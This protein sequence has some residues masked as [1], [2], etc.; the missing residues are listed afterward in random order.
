MQIICTYHL[1][2]PLANENWRI[3]RQCLAQCLDGQDMAW[4]LAQD[5]GLSAVQI[6]YTGHARPAIELVACGSQACEQLTG[7]ALQIQ[8]S[9]SR[10][11]GA[12]VRLQV[13]GG[14][15]AV[16]SGS[17]LRYYHIRRLIWQHGRSG[18]WQRLGAMAREGG[19]A[20][21]T[22]IRGVIEQG[23][24]RMADQFGW[25][26]D[27]EGT[28]LRVCARPLP[29]VRIHKDAPRLLAS[30]QVWFAT[31]YEIEGVWH[32]GR[33]CGRGFGRINRLRHRPDT[34]VD[35]PAAN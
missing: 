27:E 25:S 5:N 12:G 32:V 2:K 29:P 19:P 18:A 22:H 20:L 30:A 24:L 35:N 23:L 8:T 14:P 11:L 17:R 16:R 10:H 6:S 28:I 7:Q 33:L 1:P 13:S 3:G 15:C 4:L 9:L 34:L 21:E 31:N 26:H